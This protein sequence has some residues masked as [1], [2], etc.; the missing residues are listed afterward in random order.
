MHMGAI[1]S[2]YSCVLWL[3]MSHPAYPPTPGL[4]ILVVTPYSYSQPQPQ[5]QPQPHNP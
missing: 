1:P 4:N 2:A 5:P 3:A